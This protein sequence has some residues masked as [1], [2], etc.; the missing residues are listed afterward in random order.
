MF[1][2]NGGPFLQEYISSQPGSTFRMFTEEE[3][4]K[5]T[6]SFRYDQIIG[7]GGHGIVYRGRLE[8]NTEVAI[9]K[10]KMVDE[11]QRKEFAREMAILSQ[12]NHVSVVKLVGCCLEVEIPILV[13]EFVQCGTLFDFIHRKKHTEAQSPF[14]PV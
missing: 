9:K 2:Q 11:R 1:E 10:S 4:A 7:R 12:I 6:S 3:L 14:A 5:A 8:D 13:Y